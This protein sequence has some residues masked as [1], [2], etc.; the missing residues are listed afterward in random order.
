MQDTILPILLCTVLMICFWPLL[1]KRI[2]A[3]YVLLLFSLGGFALIS[4]TGLVVLLFFSVII[5]YGG[6]IVNHTKDGKIFFLIIALCLLPLILY[7]TI[8]HGKEFTTDGNN[9]FEIIGISYFSFNGLSYIFDIRRGYLTPEKNYGHLLLYLSFLPCIAAG[10]LHRYKYLDAQFSQALN[11]SG[12]D[13]A[14]GFRLIL[15]GLFKNLVMAQRLRAIAVPILDNPTGY[16][17]V[18]VW[19]GGLAFFLQ[20]YC[21]FSA[22][23]DVSMGAA[24]MLGV[25]LSPNF[26]NRV[27][28]SSSRSEFWKGW[29][30]TLNAWFRDY[31]FFPLV[32]GRSNQGKID[33]VMLIT[34]IL[35]GLW[36]SISWQFLLWGALNGL[37]VIGETKI[38][39]RLPVLTSRFWRIAGVLYHVSLASCVAVI[40]RTTNLRD[41]WQALVAPN[42]Q[43]FTE[44]F[45]LA[46]F[47]FIAPLF[48]F[49]D[50]VNRLMKDDTIDI[51][52]ARQKRSSRWVF[53]FS[54][55][56]MIMAFGQ[57]PGENP[58]YVRF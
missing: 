17:G 54:I 51:Y 16:Q 55:A 12:E 11:I 38:R 29:H 27:Y 37:W 49:M 7:K 43:Q 2:P 20:L 8:G 34:F 6:R 35:I 57:F 13:L 32:K 41:S 46:K 30:Q 1:H 26:S 52:L 24:R 18:F 33:A 21:D 50:I 58:Y 3:R 22:Y 42:K 40:F 45:M 39:N 25:Q 4:E 5:Y 56:L 23:V 10:P 31:V 28:A 14:R 9:L 15:W 36:H 47:I 19:L 44:D 48:L 53:Y